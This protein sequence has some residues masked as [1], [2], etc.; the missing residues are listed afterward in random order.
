MD[1]YTNGK[2]NLVQYDY[3]R[4]SRRRDP[5]PPTRDRSRSPADRYGF[6]ANGWRASPPRGQKSSLPS[7][8]P[9]PPDRYT[10]LCETCRAP[11]SKYTRPALF[12]TFF[13]LFAFFCRFFEN[14]R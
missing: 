9:Y 10:P 4:N 12:F 5:N 7:L 11:D 6:A 3:D 13:L 2:H 1:R 14:E 8:K